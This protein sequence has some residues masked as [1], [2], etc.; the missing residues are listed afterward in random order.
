MRS[1][2]AKLDERQRHETMSGQRT[3][4]CTF[5]G[6]EGSSGYR[7]QMANLAA[8]IG[9]FLCADE[10]ALLCSSSMLRTAIIQCIALD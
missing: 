8:Y 4:A 9:I 5:L 7:D 1:L 2:L 6:R 3:S 10:C